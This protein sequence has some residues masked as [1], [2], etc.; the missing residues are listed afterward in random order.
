MHLS[1]VLKPISLHREAGGIN[2]QVKTGVDSQRGR[3]G[4]NL[5]SILNNTPLPL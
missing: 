5:D 2:K 1:L 4:F 3:M